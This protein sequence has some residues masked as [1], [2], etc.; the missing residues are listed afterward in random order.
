MSPSFLCSYSG[1]FTYPFFAS[2][3]WPPKKPVG[4]RAQHAWSIFPQAPIS[5]F[6]S[7]PARN[8][9]YWG[10]YWSILDCFSPS[11][12]VWWLHVSVMRWSRASTHAW[13]GCA[14]SP[15]HGPHLGAC[16]QGLM[17]SLPHSLTHSLIN[18]DSQVM[19]PS[20]FYYVMEG[21][22][23]ED[24]GSQWQ[25]VRGQATRAARTEVPLN[26]TCGLV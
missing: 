8:N 22:E 3:S 26:T 13:P 1:T 16:T 2:H 25:M 19:W 20:L 4:M 14:A 21:W 15:V 18:I 24:Q 23:E 7:S 10:Y 9:Q 11:S 6:Q 12:Q 17:A 5:L